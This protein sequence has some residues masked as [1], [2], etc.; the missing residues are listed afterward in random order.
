[1]NPGMGRPL[2]AGV[3]KAAGSHPSLKEPGLLTPGISPGTP[4]LSKTVVLSMDF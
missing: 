2:E 4:T 3:G 1:M